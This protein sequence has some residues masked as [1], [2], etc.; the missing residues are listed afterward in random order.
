MKRFVI[1]ITG[2]SGS[3][4]AKRL[5]ENLIAN[6]C[7]VHIIATNSGEKVFEYEIG[8]SILSFIEQQ[9]L[10][11]PNL[12]YHDNKNL[13]ASIASGSFISDGMVILPCSMGTLAKMAHGISDNLLTRAADVTLKEKR[14]LLVMPRE[15]PLSRIHLQN[16]LTL[17]DSGARI[18]PPVPAFYH[19]PSTLDD[20]INQI[21]GRVLFTLGI[22]NN[23]HHVWQGEPN[24]T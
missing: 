1:G 16:M 5:I 20:V 24:E 6:G 19:Q 21:V 4:L 9:T 23:S 14:P 12:Y 18:I 3:I 8:E 17:H 11:T 2:A 10:T 7:E 13:F 22:E 15:T